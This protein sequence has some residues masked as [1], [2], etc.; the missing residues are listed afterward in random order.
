MPI[1]YSLKGPEDLRRLPPSRLKELAQEIRDRILEVIPRNGGH[2]ASSLGCV[3]LSIA[4]HRVFE[5]PRDAMIWDVGHQSYAHKLLTGRAAAF[6]GIRRLGGISGFPKREESPHDAFNTGHSSTSISA[7]LGLRN[8]R[9]LLGHEGHVIAVIGDGALTGGMA[10]EALSHAAQIPNR[11]IVV[12]NDNRMSIGPNVGG[13]S[14]Y[15]TRLTASAPYQSF[16]NFA[17]S[18][19]LR[20]PVIGEDFYRMVYRVKKG[21]K[22]IFFRLNFFAEMGFE[23]VGPINGHDIAALEDVLRR[24]RIM[25]RPVVVHVVTKKGKGHTGAEDDPEA[26]HGVSPGRGLGSARSFT[27]VFGKL[28][29][30]AAER[31]G[32]VTA[33]TAAMAKGTGLADFAKRFPARFQD[34]GIAEQH[35]LTFAAGQAAGGLK[36]LACIYSTFLQRACDQ[37]VHDICLQSLP[38]TLCVDRAGFVGEDGETHQGLLDVSLFSSQPSLAIAGPCAADDF[39]AL[40][41]W[42]LGR[43]KPAMLRY[44]KAPCPESLPGSDAPVIEGR[45]FFAARSGA[46]FL[47]LATGGIMLEAIAAREALKLSGIEADLH[48]LRFLSRLDEAYY[49]QVL[50]SYRAT[51]IA[52]EIVIEGSPGAALALLAAKIGIEAPLVL[53]APNEP[54]AQASRGELLA[55]AGLDGPGIAAKSSAFFSTALERHA[56]Y[57]CLSTEAE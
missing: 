39:A 7:A 16:R 17:D 22:A 2:L 31:D 24:A 28:A 32:R 44:P 10:Y 25:D 50:A 37:L 43:G 20:L 40:M 9:D 54:M 15:L 11:L 12:L 19:M 13:F 21:I 45:G 4:L 3:E 56:R 42:A 47:I 18:V 52:Q 26:F 51:L 29:A 38:V 57:A 8:A 35:E 55:L 34:V 30:S 23:Y 36:P 14:K 33:I 5:S 48:C 6:D 41:A 46:D 1:L 49:A 27:D 53:S